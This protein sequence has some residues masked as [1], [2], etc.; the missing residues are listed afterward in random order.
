MM[1]APSPMGKDLKSLQPAIDLKPSS[2][3]VRALAHLE[4]RALKIIASWLFLFSILKLAIQKD[5]MAI[6]KWV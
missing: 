5:Q 2:R 3:S 4:P 1:K 6:T